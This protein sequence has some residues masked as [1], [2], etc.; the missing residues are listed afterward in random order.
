MNR[1]LYC[2]LIP[3]ILTSVTACGNKAGLKSPQQIQTEAAKKAKKDAA[4]AKKTKTDD[5]DSTAP[6]PTTDTP[7]TGMVPAT[8]ATPRLP[9]PNSP[10]TETPVGMTTPS[11]EAGQSTGK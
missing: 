6:A 3:F 8:D 11:V 7:S 5:T 2:L 9:A 4:A 10:Q 1:F